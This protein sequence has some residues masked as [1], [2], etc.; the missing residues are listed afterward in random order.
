MID[1]RMDVILIPSTQCNLRCSYCYALSRLAD[2]QR[3]SLD[4]LGRVFERVAEFFEREEVS[5]A[6]FLWPSA[7]WQTCGSPTWARLTFT[8]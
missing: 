1:C 4:A 6:R 8:P 7:R 3:M 5:S 2:K